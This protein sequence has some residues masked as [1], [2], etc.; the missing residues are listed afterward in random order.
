M[1]IERIGRRRQLAVERQ[2]LAVGAQ[3]DV[4]RQHEHA[5]R[6]ARHQHLGHA[7]L[8]GL[9]SVYY[10][11]VYRDGRFSDNIATAV[12]GCRKAVFV[13]SCA[14]FERKWFLAEIL[15]AMASGDDTKCKV[16][17][18]GDRFSVDLL[19]LD[20]RVLRSRFD[21]KMLLTE[22]AKRLA[23]WVLAMNRMSKLFS[24]NTVPLASRPG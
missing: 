4:R 11:D 5:H 17:A 21:D 18:Y 22:E 8:G 24:G 14:W 15:L 6:A 13:A 7:E 1:H 20:Q 9:P 19:A 16:I 2:A 12:V 23:D 3:V 10:A